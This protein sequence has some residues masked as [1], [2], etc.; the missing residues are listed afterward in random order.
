[1]IDSQVADVRLYCDT[2]I[3]ITLF[4]LELMH[5]GANVLANV[6]EEHYQQCHVYC[7]QVLPALLKCECTEL[8]E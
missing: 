6:T 2:N 4:L 1:M 7:S 3:A 8:P 5:P